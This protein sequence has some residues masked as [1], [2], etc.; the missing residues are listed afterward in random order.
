MSWTLTKY[1][2]MRCT[3]CGNHGDGAPIVGETKAEVIAIAREGGW[4]IAGASH[5]CPLCVAKPGRWEARQ[6]RA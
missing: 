1:W 4:R 6:N 2:E 3:A 5:T